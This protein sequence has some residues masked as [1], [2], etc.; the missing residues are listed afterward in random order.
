M[1]TGSSNTLTAHCQNKQ[2]YCLYLNIQNTQGVLTVSRP[3][4]EVI[5]EV[6]TD[7]LLWQITQTAKLYIIV[8]KD[9]PVGVR[10]SKN[11]MRGKE[12]KYK[13]MSYQHLGN[14][15][16]SARRLNST[17]NSQDFAV[18]DVIDNEIIKDLK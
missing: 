17:F 5:A 10:T 6:D 13:K 2:R 1:M 8:Y 16:L 12:Y 4:P 7:T 15:K 11:S 9:K 18:L 14:A 3:E